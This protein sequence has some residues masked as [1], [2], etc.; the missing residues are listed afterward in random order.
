MFLSKMMHRF[1]SVQ[2]SDA[3]TSHAHN[4]I[5]LTCSS[6]SSKKTLTYETHRDAEKAE[7]DILDQKPTDQKKKFVWQIFQLYK[8][9]LI[10]QCLLM[11]D[12]AGKSIR[13]TFNLLLKV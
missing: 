4:T 3:Y 13:M 7:K 11:H 6:T 5:D 2:Q 9:T 10:D 12:A 1:L 8:V